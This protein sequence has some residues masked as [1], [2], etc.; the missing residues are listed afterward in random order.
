MVKRL[1]PGLVKKL[2]KQVGVR[3]HR[4]GLRYKMHVRKGDLVQVISGDDKGKVGEVLKVI[5][6]TSQVIVAGVNIRTKHI[7]PQREGEKGRIVR[8]EAPI[9][10]S[11]VMLY[12]K[13]KE[14]ASRVCHTYTADGQ[15]VR[16]LKK[17]GEILLPSVP[18][19]G[20]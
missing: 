7:K 19:K 12:S 5:P 2:T 13:E 17:T 16:M 3:K 18:K 15:K 4:N 9:H 20:K 14:V 8:E 1:Q 6:E 10:S 11:K